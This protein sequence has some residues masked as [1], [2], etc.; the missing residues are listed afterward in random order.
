MPTSLQAPAVDEWSTEK[1]TGLPEAPPVAD[2][3]VVWPTVADAGG[4]KT[5]VWAPRPMT[6]VCCTGGAAV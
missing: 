1:V 2:R 5:M 6:M 3:V 4:V